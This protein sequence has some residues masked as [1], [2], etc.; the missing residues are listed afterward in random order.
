[1]LGV[2]PEDIYERTSRPDDTSL[3]A[4]ATRVA[5]VE[6]L[7]AE[8]LLVVEAEPAQEI[9]ARIGRVTQLRPGDQTSL[10]IDTKA[11]HLFDAETTRAI[12]RDR[13]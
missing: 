5:A 2:R 12:P 10:L 8:T 11:I 7:G 3:L 9:I 13:A 6:P 4:I 1:M